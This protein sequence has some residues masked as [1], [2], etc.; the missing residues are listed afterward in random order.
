MHLWGYGKHNGAKAADRH[1]SHEGVRQ[2]TFVES[3]DIFRIQGLFDDIIA[4]T[5]IRPDDAWQ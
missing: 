4:L 1:E 2:E 5:E 3:S